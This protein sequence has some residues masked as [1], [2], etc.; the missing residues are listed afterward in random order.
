M[1]GIESVT[2]AIRDLFN[3][4]LRKAAN[5]IPGII[6]LCSL[7]KRPG[8]STLISFGNIIQEISKEGIPTEPLPD[9]T[10]NMMNKM[11]HAV[12]KE[13]FRALKEDANIQVAI[14]PGSINV[15]ATGRK[16]WRTNNSNWSKYKHRKRKC[17]ITIKYLMYE[18]FKNY[19]KWCM[20]NTTI[21]N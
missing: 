14:A 19:N 7:A 13:T 1:L 6:M 16:C 20:V 8:L 4:K 9:G 12:I 3:N 11:I 2:N 18:I 17:F 10:P 21:N 15:V 5:V